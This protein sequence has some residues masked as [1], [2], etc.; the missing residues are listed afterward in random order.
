MA[1][2]T[3]EERQ[4]TQAA[5]AKLSEFTKHGFVRLTNS[6]NGAIFAAL[7]LAKEAGVRHIF[8]PDQGG[9]YS[10]RTYPGLLGLELT[11][12]ETDHGIIHPDTLEGPLMQ[13]SKQGRC[14]LLVPSFAGYYAEQDIAELAAVCHEQG[15]LLIEDASGALSDKQVCDGNYAD[16]IVVSFGKHKLV[17]LGY[18]GMLSSRLP[19]D[20]G[21]V[22]A[23]E[24]HPVFSMTRFHPSFLPGLP[25]ALDSVPKQLEMLFEQHRK[26]LKQLQSE[27]I[28]D[29][30][31]PERRGINIVVRCSGD[32]RERAEKFCSSNGLQFM[33]VPRYHRAKVKGI[34]I[35]IKRE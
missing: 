26:I 20:A 8:T 15:A 22:G 19:V 16:I 34:S 11:E 4:L 31:H 3:E 35:E 21:D 24:E 12:L 7:A 14:C 2:L 25:A 29:I 32:A 13:A 1:L 28:K 33:R 5:T 10:F 30:V 9:W 6:G 18:G 17:N 23:G 27:N